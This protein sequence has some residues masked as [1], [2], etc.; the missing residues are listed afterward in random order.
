MTC[1][2]RRRRYM[3]R[4][5]HRGCR[6]KEEWNKG[7]RA[8]RQAKAS[9]WVG[10]PGGGAC[11]ARRQGTQRIHKGEGGE[12][13]QGSTGLKGHT[14][15]RER[16]R[17]VYRVRRKEKEGTRKRECCRCTGVLVCLFV[18]LRPQR[19]LVGVIVMR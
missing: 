6:G 15:G 13:G 19:G 17:G 14:R 3:G 1:G 5:S 16:E 2:T 12:G 8:T 10:R 9:R 7:G 18:G 4:E 11:R